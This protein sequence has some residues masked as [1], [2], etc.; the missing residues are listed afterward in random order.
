MEWFSGSSFMRLFNILILGLF[1]CLLSPVAQ[2][3][4]LFEARLSYGMLNSDPDLNSL[5][6]DCATSA[7][8][9]TPFYGLGADGIVTL[10]IPLLPGIGIRY[11]NMKFSTSKSGLDYTANFSRTALLL[12]WRP[13]DNLIYAGPILTYGL[14]HSTDLKVTEFGVKKASYSAGS[15]SSYTVGLE[16]GVK[17]IGFSLGAEFGYQNFQWN[18]AT[19]ST[20]NAPSQDINMNGTYGKFI[21]GFSI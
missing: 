19:D 21:L 12:N 5:C 17:L 11:E 9:V 10:P 15:P 20:G 18:D 13:I 4:D 2:A 16:A 7:P 8:S 6:V 14:S 3:R 1:V